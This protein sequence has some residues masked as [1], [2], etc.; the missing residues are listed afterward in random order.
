LH[1][2]PLD[3]A[4]EFHYPL[5]VGNP[6][7]KKK[8]HHNLAA[9]QG[10]IALLG[11]ESFTQT[12]LDGGRRMGLTVKEMLTVVGGLSRH[13]FY[14]SMTTYADHKVWQD[15]Y[16]ADTPVGKEAYI[17]ITMRDEAPVIQFKEKDDGA[18]P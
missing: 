17:K 18:E 5:R 3:I 12:A 6:I 7:E 4:L 13:D 8:P 14:K 10:Q 16:H 2:G 1:C 11:A 15:V 9:V